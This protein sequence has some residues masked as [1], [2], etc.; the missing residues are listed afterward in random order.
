[1]ISNQIDTS[2]NSVQYDPQTLSADESF[3][4]ELFQ[5]RDKQTINIRY[6]PKGIQTANLE[7]FINYYS[8]AEIFLLIESLVTKRELVKSEKGVVL[9]CPK[10]GNHA[11][12]PVLLCPMCG[13]TRLGK[14]EDIH[15]HEC[16]YWGPREE[17][18]KGITLQCP[19]CGVFLDFES[20]EGSLGYFSVGDS[21][22]ECQ[23]CGSSASKNN[24]ILVCVKCNNR[25]VP[26]DAS[27][28]SSVTYSL[29][30]EEEKLKESNPKIVLE[31]KHIKAESIKE[32]ETKIPITSETAVNVSESNPDEENSQEKVVNQE[33][34]EIR[35]SEEPQ[36]EPESLSLN[37]TVEI[38]EAI[39]TS[40]S[41]SNI[42]EFDN[43]Y[44]GVEFFQKSMKAVSDI[45]SR[46]R[47]KIKTEKDPFLVTDTNENR[48]EGK[49]EPGEPV[50][51]CLSNET[52]LEIK[53]VHEDSLEIVH[54]Q[55]EEIVDE[56][57]FRQADEEAQE[58]FQEE[59]DLGFHQVLLIIEDIT[60][61]ELIIESLEEANKPINVLH[62]DNAL[63][64]LKEL[65]HRYDAII[66]DL[67][68]KSLDYEFILS[69]MEKWSITIPVIAVSN[70]VDKDFLT[71]KF[72]L[73]IEAVFKKKQR[74][75]K[76]I[77][78]ALLKV[79]ESE[80]LQ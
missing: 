43:D 24:I 66:I 8:E 68:L 27:F 6:T 49:I 52:N 44:F 42:E 70:E 5:K 40:N 22:F 23:D 73:N 14:K 10:C 55:S 3:F 20:E 1:M 65:R 60:T 25:Y 9:L 78:K 38:S 4:L 69:E 46:Q 29:A 71:G 41:D 75:Y 36:E 53:E 58:E 48:I 15:H 39:E 59:Q 7:P 74:D 56:S 16:G 62:I 21:Y 17:F 64:G 18:I 13:S 79:L 80:V 77:A 35:E 31:Q 28:L 67:E 33:T 72:A 2:E 34:F 30:S 45:F 26:S 57:S 37:E 11:N 61:S 19:R 50:E 76:K 63:T 32:T 54:E 12:M 47:R 51:E